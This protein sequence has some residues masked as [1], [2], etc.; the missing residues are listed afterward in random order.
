MGRDGGM[1][2]YHTHTH[3]ILFN[4]LNGTR[5]K[6]ILNNWWDWNEGDPFRCHS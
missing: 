5:M 3:P 1:R 4:F 2:I 6:I